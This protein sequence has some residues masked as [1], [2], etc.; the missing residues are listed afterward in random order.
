VKF[1][2]AVMAVAISWPAFSD[3]LSGF[4]PVALEKHDPRQAAT[5]MSLVEPLFRNHPESV[6]GNAT[7]KVEMKRLED[8]RYIVEVETGGML[9]DSIDGRHYRA[10]IG[11]RDGEWELQ[12][13]GERWRCAKGFMGT[14]RTWTTRPCS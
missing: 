13:L 14:M 12:A 2:L 4:K 11:R 10:L 8:R 3:E 9:D 5:L 1:A 7:L 6:E